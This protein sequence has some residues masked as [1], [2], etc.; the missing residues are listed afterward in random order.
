MN[1]HQRLFFT[2]VLSVHGNK[3]LYL[4]K[5]HLWKRL[6][7]NHKIVYKKVKCMAGVDITLLSLTF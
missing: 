4:L 3:K 2:C 5:Y 6:L 1:A 7:D